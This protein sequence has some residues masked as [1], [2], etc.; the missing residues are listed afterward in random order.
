MHELSA[1]SPPTSGTQSQRGSRDTA[2][3]AHPSVQPRAL[4][5]RTLPPTLI[6]TRSCP[7]RAAPSSR[8][9]PHDARTR[10]EASS[11]P[12]PSSARGGTRPRS[13]DFPCPAL[14]PLVVPGRFGVTKFT[15]RS[16]RPSLP[17]K[18]V[19]MQL[20]PSWAGWPRHG[21]G[22]TL[23]GTLR[24]LLLAVTG[25]SPS[26]PHGL[27]RAA[28]AR[29]VPCE[30]RAQLP[31]AAPHQHRSQRP[32]RRRT[33]L[34]ARLA[35]SAAAG[36]SGQL[37]H[38]TEKMKCWKTAGVR[39]RA[40]T[41]PR[42]LRSTRGL[43]EAAAAP[44]RRA[45]PA[46]G[47]R[48]GT[49]PGYPGAAPRSPSN[50][51]I[52]PPLSLTC[53]PV[54]VRALSGSLGGKLPTA[55]TCWRGCLPLPVR[56]GATLPNIVRAHSP[57]APS[58]APR[59]RYDVRRKSQRGA[60]LR[61]RKGA[62]PGWDPVRVLTPSQHGE[63][64]RTG[65]QLRGGRTDWGSPGPAAPVGICPHSRPPPAARPYSTPLP[66][67][68]SPLLDPS[69]GSGSPRSPPCSGR[70]HPPSGALPAPHQFP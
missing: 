33:A 52:A 1:A 23:L 57:P 7:P 54:L 24:Q 28:G 58:P 11:H 44:C 26:R 41:E 20:N 4:R 45:V 65:V 36:A 56:R 61:H 14:R 42:L 19:C 6:Q 12:R 66:S 37:L 60:G 49:A 29:G 30:P 64:R 59:P 47:Q 8:P 2:A 16:S 31:T 63:P 55:P 68:P 48:T 62:E 39:F 70:L 50:A 32:T 38:T 25:C 22:L 9:G 3:T 13:G 69:T 21:S 35:L 10:H 51:D 67:T 18:P 5:P 27:C 43:N 34:P 15:V 46:D 40:G 17:P 53:H